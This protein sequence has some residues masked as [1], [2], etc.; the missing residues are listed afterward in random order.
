MSYAGSCDDVRP[1][2]PSADCVVLPSY[3]EG[4]PRTLIEAS[5]MARPVIAT[6]VPG[7]TA[8]V[9]EGVTGLLCK[10]RDAASLAQAMQI[11][12]AMTAPE[13][14]T[15]G[16]SGRKKMEQEFDQVRVVETYMGSIGAHVAK[17]RALSG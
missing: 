14:E 12:L 2:I 11:F 1:H 5:A 7:C 13:R 16:N 4:A 10:V 15:M 9:S 6:R 17:L 8:V 3:R